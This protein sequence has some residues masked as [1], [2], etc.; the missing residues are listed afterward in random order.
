MGGQGGLVGPQLDGIANRG[1]DRV[2]ED[3]L[4]PNRN[5][6]PAFRYSNVILKDTKLITGLQRREEGEVL[7]FMDTTG[8]EVSVPKKQIKQRIESN[9]SVMPGNFGEIIPEQEFNDLV[10]YLLAQPKKN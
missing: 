1:V 4:D 10:A 9:L 2:V 6:D 8:K 3:I 5:V 7:V